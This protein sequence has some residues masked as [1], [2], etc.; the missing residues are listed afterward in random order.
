MALGPGLSPAR[1]LCSAP[2]LAGLLCIALVG[3]TVL[4][5]A[6]AC[7]GLLRSTLLSSSETSSVF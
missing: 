5:S 1:Q 4:W 2:L 7:T 3:P 6:L